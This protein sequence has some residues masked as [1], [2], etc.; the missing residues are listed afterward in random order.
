MP[1]PNLP[2][3]F[4]TD[5]AMHYDLLLLFFF[6]AAIYASAGFGGGSSYLAVLALY[7]TP[8]ATLRPVAL[9]CNLVVVSGNL[10]IFWRKGHLNWRKSMPLVLSGIPFAF[11]GGYWKLSEGVFFVLLGSS[12]IAAALAMWLQRN[13]SN[14]AGIEARALSGAT[15]AGLGGGLGFL[16]GLTG[17]GGGIFLSPALQL[18]RWDSPKV[19][20]ATASLFIFCQSAAGLTGQLLRQP[21]I[22]WGLV[23]PL[24]LAVW[25]GGQ[26][27][28]RW[29][30][31]KSPQALVR[32]LT[33]A[34]VFYAG[35]NILWRYL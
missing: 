16:A 35:V 19:I 5:M 6:I 13:P 34:L 7:S 31:G 15:N 23:L 8:M 10:F 24:L 20:A 18:L 3:T 17:I 22:D 12:L 2:A 32:N 25:V 4:A 28:V 21:A 33:A 14:A 30:A 26:I 11:G 1:N 9:L 27:G 29:S